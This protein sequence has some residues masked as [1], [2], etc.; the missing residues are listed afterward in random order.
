MSR[1]ARG[2]AVTRRHL[3]A[4]CR[5]AVAV[6]MMLSVWIV[7]TEILLWLYRLPQRSFVYVFAA[8]VAIFYAIRLGRSLFLSR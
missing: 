1:R 6:V 5:I 7:F 4:A 2:Q 8:Q 3:V